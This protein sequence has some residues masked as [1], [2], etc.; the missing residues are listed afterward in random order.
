MLTLIMAV[1]LAM[2]TGPAWGQVSIFSDDQGNSGTLITPGRGG[3]SFYNDSAG[4]SGTIITPGNGGV[5]FYNFTSPSGDMRSGTIITPGGRSFESE[6]LTPAL[7]GLSSSPQSDR[8]DT[9]SSPSRRD[10]ARW[11]R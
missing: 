9:W 11:R 1:I 8:F 5:S 6:R 10:G 3:M 7:P 4:N 2:A